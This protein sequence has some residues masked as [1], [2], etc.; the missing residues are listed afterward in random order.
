MP[1]WCQ[2]I[3]NEV[4]QCET[5]KAPCKQKFVFWLQLAEIVEQSGELFKLEKE[6][7]INMINKNYDACHFCNAVSSSRKGP[8]RERAGSIEHTFRIIPRWLETSIDCG[9]TSATANF[10]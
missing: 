1:S 8:C 3:Q 4:L 5:A 2:E 7:L 6:V 9:E 10:A